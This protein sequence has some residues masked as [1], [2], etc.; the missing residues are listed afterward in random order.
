[1]LLGAAACAL[2]VGCSSKTPP[3]GKVAGMVT[4]KGHP[5][6]EGSIVFSD[7]AQG[8]AIVSDLDGEGRFVFEVARGRG[9]PPGN[10]RVAIMPPGRAKPSLEFVAP[11]VQRTRLSFPNIPAKYLNEATSGLIAVVQSG[12]NPEFRF[13]LDD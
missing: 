10:Y 5:L 7:A 3:L 6:T 8:L 13:E 9:L 11:S 12:E 2:L 1:M 4:F